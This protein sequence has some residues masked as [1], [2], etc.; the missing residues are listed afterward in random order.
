MAST[1]LVNGAGGGTRIPLGIPD[2]NSATYITKTGD[3]YLA[4]ND[5]WVYVM[6]KGK[7][8]EENIKVNG[9]LIAR[10]GN[11][12]GGGN[13]HGHTNSAF[14]PIGKDDKI[15]G[16]NIQEVMFYPMRTT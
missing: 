7:Y 6:T 10:A 13:D 9:N 4:P 16:D 11:A 15:T 1:K 14:F 8:S 3:Y 5:G 12:V 2:Y